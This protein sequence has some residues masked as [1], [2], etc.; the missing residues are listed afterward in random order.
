MI[1]KLIIGFFALF[2]LYL[3][4]IAITTILAQKNEQP[5]QNHFSANNTF[6][7][8]LGMEYQSNLPPD[9]FAEELVRNSD[10]K[11]FLQSN[12]NLD[13]KTPF[14]KVWQGAESCF[15][16][17]NNLK[18]DDFITKNK[19]IISKYEELLTKSPGEEI[20][21][22]RLDMMFGNQ[23]QIQRV[24]LCRAMIDYRK[25][26]NPDSLRW[27]AKDFHFWMNNLVNAKSIDY[28]FSIAALVRRDVEAISFFFSHYSEQSN[29][30][31]LAGMEKDL[32]K[33]FFWNFDFARAE[34]FQIEKEIWTQQR[35]YESNNKFLKL[36][37]IPSAYRKVSSRIFD[38][39]RAGFKGRLYDDWPG[40]KESLRAEISD[41]E[42]SFFQ[43]EQIG[44]GA[45]LKKMMF[46]PGYFISEISA[47]LP[48]P[49]L[50]S[51]DRIFESIEKAKL[52]YALILS[53]KYKLDLA[54]E[55]IISKY[56]L[57]SSFSGSYPKFEQD[58]K[59]IFYQRKNKDERISLLFQ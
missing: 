34:S 1:K 41:K 2:G 13:L 49:R 45:L 28:T 47:C 43:T 48:S 11:I 39:Y 4:F 7:Y 33:I 32:N 52:L 46:F 29:Q 22:P 5:I 55:N 20:L 50:S 35:F 23:I 30:D 14:E 21:D 53:K 17:S 16:L 31:I 26:S 25:S 24:L 51:Y 19:M 8:I 59:S 15:E 54:D 40:I 18:L 57:A 36:F 3:S 6:Y 12:P 9:K 38:K 27:I 56:K 42:C 58:Q 37:F 10:N 44:Y